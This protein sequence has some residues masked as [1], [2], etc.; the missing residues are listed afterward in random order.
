MAENLTNG[1]KP[2]TIMVPDDLEAL[3][4]DL[5]RFFDAMVYKLRRNKNK[6]RWEDLDVDKTFKHLIGEVEELRAA[7]AE[8]SSMEVLMEG[9]D[10]GNFAMILANI[11]VEN[12]GA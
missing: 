2:L 4:P 3:R 7:I 9:A 5:Q 10:V 12:K 6:G 1:A 11:A 8:G